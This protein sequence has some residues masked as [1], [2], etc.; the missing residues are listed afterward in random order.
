[1]SEPSLAQTA[2]AATLAA[3]EVRRTSAFLRRLWAG[4]AV[5]VVASVIGF[6]IWAHVDNAQVDSSTMHTN[7]I[8]QKAAV[9]NLKVDQQVL[10]SNALAACVDAQIKGIVNGLIADQTAILAGKTPPPFV[11]PST[12]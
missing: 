12:C 3:D 7:V 1:M 10:A 4:V 9:E 11:F 5:T 2:D 6:L 8:V